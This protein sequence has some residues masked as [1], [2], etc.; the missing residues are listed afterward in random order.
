[1]KIKSSCGRY[2]SRCDQKHNFKTRVSCQCFFK[3]FSIYQPPSASIEIHC[4]NFRLHSRKFISVESTYVLH[5]KIVC[6][7]YAFETKRIN[8]LFLVILVVG[9]GDCYTV[10]CCVLRTS[11]FLVFK[12][13]LTQVQITFKITSHSLFSNWSLGCMCTILI[14]VRQKNFGVFCHFEYIC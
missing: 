7:A 12:V 13:V 8:L 9:V 2:S 6:T 4:K 1:M 11:Q 10:L 14:A 5:T 3:F